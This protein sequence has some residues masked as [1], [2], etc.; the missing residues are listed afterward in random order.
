MDNAES[1]FPTLPNAQLNLG[2]DSELF[3]ELE[4]YPNTRSRALC[5]VGFAQAAQGGE[6]FFEGLSNEAFEEQLRDGYMRAALGEFVSIEEIFLSEFAE[7]EIRSGLKI[8]D[9]GEL[10]PILFKE[11]R[12]LNFHVSSTASL[13]HASS[14]KVIVSGSSGEGSVCKLPVR[15]LA[16]DRNSFCELDNLKKRRYWAQKNVDEILLWFDRHQRHVGVHRLLAI[17]V[18]QYLRFLLKAV[19][20]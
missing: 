16:Y 11:F 7:G 19:G 17:A 8:Y 10:L 12:N 1:I 6:G 4:N 13:E 5:S 14:V 20:S 18:D 15:F 9:T 3:D 2:I